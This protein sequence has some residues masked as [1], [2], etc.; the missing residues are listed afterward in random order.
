MTEY[1]ISR[2]VVDLPWS[3]L[4]KIGLPGKSILRDYFQEN[5]GV[6]LKK[7]FWE[8]LAA[9]LRRTTNF[10][11]YMWENCGAVLMRTI[12]EIS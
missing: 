10:P 8:N 2:S 11:G 9:V 12:V 1:S 6:F 3:Q 4:H 7:N 5:R